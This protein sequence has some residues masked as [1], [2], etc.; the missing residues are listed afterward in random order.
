MAKFACGLPLY[1]F[2]LYLLLD[3][4][5]DF[6]YPHHHLHKCTKGVGESIS[7]GGCRIKPVMRNL[8][9]VIIEVFEQI[10]QFHWKINQEKSSFFFHSFSTP[11]IL[12]G[13]APWEQCIMS[14]FHSKHPHPPAP[15]KAHISVCSIHFIFLRPKEAK[16]LNQLMPRPLILVTLCSS[17]HVF[18]ILFSSNIPGANS[19]WLSLV[20][21][22]IPVNQDFLWLCGGFMEEK[23]G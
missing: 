7:S 22:C 8:H 23:V 2:C 3:L 17:L 21:R 19:E 1:L 15:R 14:W 10:T 11:A 16:A 5:W 20:K 4:K 6:T 12:V 18:P 9:N 13:C